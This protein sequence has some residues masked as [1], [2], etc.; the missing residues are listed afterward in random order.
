MHRIRLMGL[1]LIAVFAMGAI[2]ATAAMAEKP[3][4]SPPEKNVFSTSGG[5]AKFEQK[6]GIAPV[7]AE[8]STGKGEVT[9]A[10]E[11]TF[12][13][14]F[15]NTTVPLGG[16]ATGLED[17]TVGS[18]LV[19]GTF[20]LGYLDAAKTKVGVVFKIIETHFE[21][22]KLITLVSVRGAAIG[23]ITPLNT[24]T[25][26]FTVELTGAGGVQTFTE[27]LNATNSGFEKFKLESEI[28]GGAFT[29]SDEVTTVKITTTK[30]ASIVA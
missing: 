30:E 14:L 28:N 2:A 5:K 15:E 11:G 16:K 8:K 25:K 1:A 4:F 13:E 29:Q 24:K 18:V 10:K 27:I 20:K 6:E 19:K 7:S 22:E 23:Q 3:E 17:K 12:D 21:A 9:N 26:V